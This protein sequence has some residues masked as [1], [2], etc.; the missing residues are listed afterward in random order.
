MLIYKKPKQNNP[1]GRP[2]TLTRTGILG[3]GREGIVYSSTIQSGRR[4]RFVAEKQYSIKLP[5]IYPRELAVDAK[6]NW[7]VLRRLRIPTPKFYVPL[8]RKANNNSYRVLMQDLHKKHGKL[9][10]IN[11]SYGDPVFL[12]KLRLPKDKI[13]L[14]QLASDLA[15]INNA[16]YC[17]DFLDLWVLYKKKDG[18]YGRVAVDYGQMNPARDT[19]T[20]NPRDDIR[21][22][23]I[24][25]LVKARKN[26]SKK[27]FDYF[28]AEYN[29]RAQEKL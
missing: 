12:Q 27:E 28:L 24:N 22:S 17:L 11:D 29:K 8:I 19:P 2:Y 7:V 1:S 10:K 21:N 9:F 13:I 4:K 25:N 18:T 3:R 23:A 14:R 6:R 5:K 26:M 16:G 15:A 20:I